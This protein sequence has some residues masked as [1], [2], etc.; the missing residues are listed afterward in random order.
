MINHHYIIAV[1]HQFHSSGKTLRLSLLPVKSHADSY[2][3][4]FKYRIG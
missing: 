2:S 1:R 4:Y 3:A